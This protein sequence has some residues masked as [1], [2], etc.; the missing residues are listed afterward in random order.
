MDGLN[1]VLFM[2]IALI[3]LGLRSLNVCRN[4]NRLHFTLINYYI[5]C[6]ASQVA[7]CLQESLWK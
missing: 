7:Q 3:N 2:K 5:C 4:G 1:N 6:N